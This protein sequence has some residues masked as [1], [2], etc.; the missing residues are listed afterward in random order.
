MDGPRLGPSRGGVPPDKSGHDT[1][2]RPAGN[3]PQRR[4]DDAAV[5]REHKL[6]LILGFAVVMIVGVLVGDHFSRARATTLSPEVATPAGEAI[7]L[8]RDPAT[9][10]LPALGGLAGPVGGGHAVVPTTLAVPSGM[11]L[12]PEPAPQPDPSPAEIKMGH[13]TIAGHG[14]SASGPVTI[15][16]QAPPAVQTDEVEAP[17]AGKGLP[18]SAGLEKRYVIEQGD[19]LYR[20][21]EAM[22]G[23]ASLHSALATYNKDKLPSPTA[24]RVGVTL[25]VPPRDVL[26]G[27]AVLGPAA[28]TQTTA[29]NVTPAGGPTLGAPPATKPGAKVEPAKDPLAPK[30]A[31]RTYTVKPGDTLG[32]IARS[33]LGTSKRWKDILEANRKV[34]ERDDQLKVGM[35]LKIPA[36]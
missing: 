31:D 15:N 6:A 13:G 23:D 33:Q 9:D 5:T 21:A 16:V 29:V 11:D 26:L 24:L 36:K 27:E 1:G 14:P 4:K 8:L 7:G 25:R 35:V 12:Q 3:R 28:K 32:T 18:V 30:P 17:G 20:I 2:G 22:Y 19:S 10:G 34:L